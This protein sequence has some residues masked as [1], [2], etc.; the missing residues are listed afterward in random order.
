MNDKNIN[1]EATHTLNTAR[2]FIKVAEKYAEF[3][4]TEGYI[5]DNY[6]LYEV[7]NLDASL[8]ICKSG[9]AD[10]YYDKA[11][12]M[13]CNELGANHPETRQLVQEIINYH[14]NNVKRMM[15]E[16]FFLTGLFILPFLLLVSREYF[17]PSWQSCLVYIVSYTFLSLF[18]YLETC[19]MCYF[20]KCNC[21]KRYQKQ[22]TSIRHWQNR[23]W[24]R[25]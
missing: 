18:C 25:L 8:D 10:Y 19:L 1:A 4:K 23:W 16:R 15:S 5:E 7:I 9:P 11:Y 20:E 17:G 2:S 21:Q 14:L 22:D 12:E 6:T 13:M 24:K 3:K